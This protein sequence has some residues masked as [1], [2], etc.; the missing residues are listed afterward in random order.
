MR[1]YDKWAA[2]EGER[3]AD[4]LKRDALRGD[5]SKR[6]F[7]VPATPDAWAS[8]VLARDC[9]D[10]A[11]PLVLDRGRAGVGCIPYDAFPCRI[12]DACRDLP[13]FPRNWKG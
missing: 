1:D 8:I 9:P 11:T 13:V 2:R 10:G 4:E 5:F 12:R 6:A 7:L 3:L